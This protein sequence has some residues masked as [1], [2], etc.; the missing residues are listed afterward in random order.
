MFARFKNLLIVVIRDPTKI[1]LAASILLTD[2]PQVLKHKMSSSG[3]T[4]EYV[5]QINEQYMMWFKK[6]YPTQAQLDAQMNLAKTYKHQPLISIIVPTY[7]TQAA[8]L[9]TCIE[10]VLAQ[11]YP[12]WELCIADDCSTDDKVRDT[13]LEFSKKDA[14]VKYVFRKTNGHISAASNS[15]I[16]IASGKWIGLLDHDDFLWPNALFEVIKLLN[17]KPKTEFIY[18]DEDKVSVS[19]TH[20]DPHFKPNWSPLTLLSCNYITHFALLSSSIMKKIGGFRVGF[21]GSQDYD[22]F[23]RACQHTDKIEHIPTILYSWRAIPNSTA[24]GRKDVKPYAYTSAVKA[25]Q[26][27]LDLRSLPYHIHESSRGFYQLSPNYSKIH[28]FSEDNSQDQQLLE[29]MQLFNS[30]SE[31]SIYFPEMQ[32]MNHFSIDVLILNTDILNSNAWNSP[33]GGSL[34]RAYQNSIV[35]LN[36]DFT[37]ILPE[38]QLCSTNFLIRKSILKNRNA[39]GDAEVLREILKNKTINKVLL[40][41]KLN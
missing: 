12:N 26:E 29:S 16:R 34:K 22:L 33:Y 1:I 13:I 21:E 32:L 7:N 20:F 17:E 31:K 3:Q 41:Y 40:G 37:G 10:S 19:G 27:S 24:S 11:S 2:G 28:R 25:L 39:N 14:R 23:L 30:K 6:N 36:F 18:S 5:K 35:N 38:N 9:T 15:A 8:L 4:G